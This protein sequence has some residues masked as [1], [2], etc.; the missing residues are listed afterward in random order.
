MASDHSVSI[1]EKPLQLNY[2]LMIQ[3]SGFNEAI[4]KNAAD[5]ESNMSSTP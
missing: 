5:I 4:K 3:S 1:L 2:K